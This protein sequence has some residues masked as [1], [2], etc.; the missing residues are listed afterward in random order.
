M[1]NETFLNYRGYRFL[2][3]NAAFVLLLIAGYCWD[4]PINGA[5][6]GTVLGYAYGV[7]ATLGILYL[8]WFGMRK[9]SYHARF[10]T[11]RGCLSAHT[12]L[13]LALLIIV[14]LHCAF[15]FGW[16]VH[17]LAYVLMVMVIVSGSSCSV[18]SAFAAVSGSSTGMRMKVCR[19]AGAPLPT[20]E[21]SSAA[22]ASSA[23]A[24]A[25]A[26]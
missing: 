21:T 7:V 16:N 14:P 26:P 13:G 15:Q 9:R 17:T 11:L 23:T 6:G 10:T 20:I 1:R 18:G 2:W 19:N 22:S 24:T 25:T 8:M 5:S 12:Y 3:L 4:A